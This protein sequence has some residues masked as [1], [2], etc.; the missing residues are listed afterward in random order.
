D[1]L[2]AVGDLA[3]LEGPDAPLWRPGPPPP[4]PHVD[5]RRD[6][7]A[8]LL[9]EEPQPAVRGEGVPADGRHADHRRCRS[10]AA[11]SA[12][13]ETAS[14]SCGPC[15]PGTMAHHDPVARPRQCMIPWGMGGGAVIG[16]RA[17]ALRGPGTVL[18]AGPRFRSGPGAGVPAPTGAACVLGHIHAPAGRSPQGYCAILRHVRYWGYD[19]PDIHPA[20]ARAAVPA[21]PPTRPRQAP[22]VPAPAGRPHR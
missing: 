6:G 18:I 9:G 5:D 11:A 13:R 10:T 14:S 3:G 17:V 19:T 22:A 7:A 15:R 2:D 8:G 12:S 21:R 1:V 20:G 16:P 4:A